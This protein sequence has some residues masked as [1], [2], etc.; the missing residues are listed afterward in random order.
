MAAVREVQGGGAQADRQ[1]VIPTK[2]GAGVILKEKCET[3]NKVIKYLEGKT[4][5]LEEPVILT[6]DLLDCPG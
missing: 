2:T 3:G 5:Y 1:L 6:D 4:F